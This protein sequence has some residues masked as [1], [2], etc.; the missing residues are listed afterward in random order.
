MGSYRRK[1][2]AKKDNQEVSRRK[3]LLA[4]A[5]SIYSKLKNKAAA[6]GR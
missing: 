4:G 3:V 1:P 5:P 6:D 2:K